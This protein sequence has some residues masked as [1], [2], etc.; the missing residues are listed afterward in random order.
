MK[1][2][3]IGY[4]VSN[5]FQGNG[6]DLLCK[7]LVTSAINQGYQ[8]VKNGFYLVGCL[9]A[10]RFSCSRCIQYKGNINFCKSTFFCQKTFY[11]DARNTHGLIGKKM[12]R[13]T[14]TQ[15]SYRRKVNVLFSSVQYDK[16]GFFLAPRV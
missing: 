7:D 13:R 6:D 14:I 10:K 11:K 3:Y 4:I 9:T 5:Q 8:I 16:L 12:C 1:I 2:V 15:K